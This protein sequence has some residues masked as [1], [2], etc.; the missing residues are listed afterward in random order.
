MNIIYILFLSMILFTIG[1]YGVM[2]SK[3]G[4]KVIISLEIV[5]NSALLDV[6][7]VASLYYSTSVVV[8]SLFVIA[9]GVIESAVGIA[10]FTLISKKYGKINISLLG[11]IKW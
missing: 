2:T 3:V 10:I 7:G 11:D 5:L 6:V 4:M 8:F 9:I 1:I